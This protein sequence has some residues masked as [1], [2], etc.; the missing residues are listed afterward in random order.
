MNRKM[1]FVVFS[2][3]SCRQNHALLYANDL[4]SKGHEIKVIIEG[5]ATASLRNL[6]DASSLFSRLFAQAKG[7]GLLVG[8]CKRA[9]GGCA[10]GCEERNVTEIAQQQGL[11]LLDDCEGHAGI[12]RFV[13][14]GYEVVVF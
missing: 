14:E 10:T 2:D 7:A 13:R 3:D 9:S 12:E 6:E 5:A 4:H 11:A 1:L 8:A